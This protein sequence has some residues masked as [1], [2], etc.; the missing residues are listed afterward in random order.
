MD[1]WTSYFDVHPR[2][3]NSKH[4]TYHQWCALPTR[5]VLV[6]HSPYTIPRYML[7]DLPRDGICSVARFRLCAHTLQIETV[8][9]TH[10]TSP[11]CDLCNAH[12]EQHIQVEQHVLFHCTHPHVVS[13]QRTYA[14]LFPSAGFN[15]VLGQGNNKLYSSLHALI[16]FYEQA[17]SRTS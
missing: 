3:R 2:E 8:T 9:W 10:N 11:T 16:L 1:Y 15:N 7:L 17:S 12:D 6:T 14:S 13:L 4:S 5:R